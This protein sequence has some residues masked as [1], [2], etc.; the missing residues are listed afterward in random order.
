VSYHTSP[1]F[2]G[3]DIVFFFAWMP[4]IVAGG[5]T[6]LSLDGVIA[7]RVAQEK[8]EPS[9]ELVPIPFATVQR[10]CGNYSRGKCKARSGLACDAGFCPVLL[11]EKAPIATPVVIGSVDRRTMVLGGAGRRRGRGGGV[12]RGRRRRRRRKVGEWGAPRRK[13]RPSNS[14][15]SPVPTTTPTTT[16]T[17]TTRPT[18][19][20]TTT[21]TDWNDDAHDENNDDETDPHDGAH[22]DQHDRTR[23]PRYV[24]RCRERG[25]GEP[26]R[27][28]QHSLER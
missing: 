27:E 4:F 22:H 21:Q 20:T 17:R 7:G 26:S 3:A 1:Y 16:P 10:L 8:G 5:G 9:P 6:R 19:K 15:R 12:T 23:H 2:T 11:G 24:A 13:I 25:A 28:F 18:T 14:P